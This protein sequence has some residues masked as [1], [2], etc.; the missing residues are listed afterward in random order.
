MV[1]EFVVAARL[2]EL[3]AR[4][5]PSQAGRVDLAGRD[6]DAEHDRAHLP[7]PL[8]LVRD[9]TAAR[10]Q[11]VSDDAGDEQRSRMN[12]VAREHLRPQHLQRSCYANVQTS[13]SVC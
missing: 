11:P 12:H 5:D 9:L 8:G 2:D 4:H 10:R 3:V 13:V 1:V 6:G 7:Q